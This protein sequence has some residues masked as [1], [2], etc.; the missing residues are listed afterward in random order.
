MKARTAKKID[1]SPAR[2]HPHQIAK[3]KTILDRISRK[4]A[5]KAA[6]ETVAKTS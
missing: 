6:N 4:E 3:A 1:K 5:K 2:Y